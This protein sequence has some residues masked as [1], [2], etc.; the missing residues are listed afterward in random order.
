VTPSEWLADNLTDVFVAVAKAQA[1]LAGS[2]ANINEIQARQ[3]QAGAQ[4]V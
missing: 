3:P 2:S 1:I 4:D